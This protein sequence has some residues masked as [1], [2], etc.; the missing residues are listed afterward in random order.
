MVERIE[1]FAAEEEWRRAYAEI[2][3]FEDELVG[4]GMVL[5][6]FWMHIT[7][8]EQEERFLARAENSYN[9]W[10][11]TDEDWR[12][13]EHWEAYETAVNDMVERTST[14][15]APWIL[16]EG[17]DKRHARVRVIE[18]V[19]TALERVLGESEGEGPPGAG[20]A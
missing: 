20:E 13:R 16:V 19:C 17:N 8:E 14:R 12:N 9:S 1:G 18:E 15:I 11:L 7:Q 6:K 10:K 2:N 5:V 3:E 4:H